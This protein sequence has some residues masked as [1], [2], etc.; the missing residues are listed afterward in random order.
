MNAHLIAAYTVF[1]GVPLAMAIWLTLRH[2]KVMRD[3]HSLK[4]MSRDER[5]A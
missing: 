3:I 1:C 4:E 5:T 2:R